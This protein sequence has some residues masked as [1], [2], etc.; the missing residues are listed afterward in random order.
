MIWERGSKAEVERKIKT[1]CGATS[2][3]D[4]VAPAQKMA[5]RERPAGKA[6]AS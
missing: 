1:E 4:V 6:N 3:M 5:E 2:K